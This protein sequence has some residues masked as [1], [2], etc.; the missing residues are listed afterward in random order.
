[1]LDLLHGQAM[2]PRS[3]HH[4]H[5]LSQSRKTRWTQQITSTAK[6][7]P[8]AKLLG[9]VWLGQSSSWLQWKLSLR[10]AFR[11]WPLNTTWCI[12]YR[13]KIFLLNAFIHFHRTLSWNNVAEHHCT[14]VFN[15]TDWIKCY[16]LLLMTV[17]CCKIILQRQLLFSGK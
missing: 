5:F 16:L 7:H 3:F 17:Q 1:M 10:E 6:W 12:A 9:C 14:T 13:W 8:T 4:W 2:A 15:L 11:V